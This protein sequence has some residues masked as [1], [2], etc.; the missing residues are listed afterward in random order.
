MVKISDKIPKF[1]RG[2]KHQA[3]VDRPNVIMGNFE[4]NY[5]EVVRRNRFVVISFVLTGILAVAAFI[6]AAVYQS[7]AD[8]QRTIVEVEDGKITNP[9]QIIVVKGDI[10]A[11]GAGYIEFGK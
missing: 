3:R 7:T 10:E 5:E 6:P 1:K 9:A 2:V 11:G 8:S 4:L